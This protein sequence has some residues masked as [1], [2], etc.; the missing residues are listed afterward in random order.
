MRILA[1]GDVH[2]CY[3]TFKK[4]VDEHFDPTSMFLVQLGDLIN[5]GPHSAQCI[6]FAQQLRKKYPYQVFFLK[7]NHEVK[8]DN[9]GKD[10]RAL[11]TR[12]QLREKGIDV[13][14]LHKWVSS[15]P[16]KW[17]NP[18]ILITHAGVSA[19]SR[20]PFS[21]Q[22]HRGVLF[23]RQPLAN[24]GKVQI[25]GHV[26]QEDY[27]PRYDLQANAWYIETGCWQGK[28]LTALELSYNGKILGVYRQKTLK[29]DLISQPI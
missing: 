19:H 14:R 22:N 8:I 9:P 3:Y 24:V 12:R 25:V 17:E 4:L 21:E 29:S 23:N 26:L 27:R 20:V 5:K 2:G 18:K 15:L 6:R 1:V 16:L 11:K 7:G 10:P 28:Y 13:A